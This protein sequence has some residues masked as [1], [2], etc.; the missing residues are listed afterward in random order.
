MATQKKTTVADNAKELEALKAQMAQM[1]DMAARL[2]ALEAEK[3][4]AQAEAQAATEELERTK[5]AYASKS[6]N[7]VVSGV[8]RVQI[9]KAGKME[10]VKM[11]FRTNAPP[12]IMLLA[13]DTGLPEP[14]EVS[15]QVFFD[16]A[17]GKAIPE[18]WLNGMSKHLIG[19][20]RKANDR[21]TRALETYAKQLSPQSVIFERVA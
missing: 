3:A 13:S 8:I 4:A 10:T 20:D 2:E 6:R 1:A 16:L 9:K 12:R 17:S 11:Q 18:E 19:A 15:K 14:L 7:P 21:F 5:Q